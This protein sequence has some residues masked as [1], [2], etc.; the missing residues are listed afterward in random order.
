MA[1]IILKDSHGSDVIYRDVTSV[2]LRTEGDSFAKFGEKMKFN[3]AYGDMPPADTTKLWIK[4]NTPEN[5]RII[6]P[7]YIGKGN[8]SAIYSEGEI[9]TLK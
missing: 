1:N 2:Q 3:I 8:L 6:P 9:G 7:S 5:M 4:Y